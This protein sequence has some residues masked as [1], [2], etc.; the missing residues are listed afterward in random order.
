MAGAVRANRS[1]DLI[2]RDRLGRRLFRGVG[3]AHRENRLTRVLVLQL[4]IVVVRQ[5]ARRLVELDLAQRHNRRL[6]TV[7]LA[8][9][10]FPR[11]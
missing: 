2:V 5:L 10:L 1:L 3:A 6:P 9:A 4:A 11:A 8:D 7:R